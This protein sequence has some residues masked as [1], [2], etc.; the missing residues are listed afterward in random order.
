MMNGDEEDGEDENDEENEE[1]DEIGRLCA[2]ANLSTYIYT[3][4][5]A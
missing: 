1:E 5:S 2:D 4:I 3:Y